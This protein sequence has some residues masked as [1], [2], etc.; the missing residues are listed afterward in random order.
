M[1][2]AIQKLVFALLTYLFQNV[3]FLIMYRICL[4]NL[5]NNQFYS[6]VWNKV[7]MLNDMDEVNDNIKCGSIT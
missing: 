5:L 2:F 3:N 6:K 7:D 1:N 4:T